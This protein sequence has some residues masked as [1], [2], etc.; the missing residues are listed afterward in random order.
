MTDTASA[1]P[2]HIA[3][4]NIPA[5][6]HVNP[7]LGI[8]AELV[9]RGHR[10]SYAVPE[11][12]GPQ[13]RAAGAGLVP[14]E[15]TL[16]ASDR[17]EDW[18]SDD[19]VAMLGLALHEAV[20]VLP[21]QL[22]AFAADPPDLVL[23]D[24]GALTGRLLAHRHGVRAVCVSSTHVSAADPAER[25][26]RRELFE[27]LFH[28]DPRWHEYQR[29][30]RKLLDDAGIGMSVDDYTGQPER[31]LVPIPRFFQQDGERVDE[32][33]AFVG[34]C[35]GGRSHQGHWREPA[36]GTPV[37][38]VAL[39]TAGSDR[40]EFYRRCVRAFTGTPWHVVM[41]TGRLDPAHIGPLPDNVETHASV[42]QLRVLARADAFITHAGMGSVLE[43]MHHGVPMVA[44]PQVNDQPVNAARI[45]ELGLGIYL[46]QEE[47]TVHALR[48]AVF[49]L[50]ADPHV[51]RRTAGIRA[52][53]RR[54]GGA[55][56]AAGLI[57]SQLPGGAGRWQEL[58]R[59]LEFA[60]DHREAER[61][62][63]GTSAD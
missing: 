23:H 22:R 51:A 16:P 20:S 47:A 17:V 32:R 13:V 33:Y 39:G 3:V 49:S 36:E 26:A 18:P 61:A 59:R 37:L 55:A 42:P 53:M 15:T 50:A 14:Y 44:V 56:A 60:G 30:F 43:A 19:P 46:A 35:L 34:P 62:V 27:E 54:L 1:R 58:A 21:G 12:F 40:P 45:A 28:D 31:C 2:A 10:V 11:E 38:L 63:H 48:D 8:V 57:E 25:Q 24:F 52:R 29:G 7:T 4:L 9:R 41:A 6:G 5:H